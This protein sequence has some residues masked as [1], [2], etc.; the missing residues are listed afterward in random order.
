MFATRRAVTCK[1]IQ[2][3]REAAD[4]LDYPAAVV[5]L[6]PLVHRASVC[7]V[8]AISYADLR[9]RVFRIDSRQMVRRI[10]DSDYSLVLT[11]S[12]RTFGTRRE[13]DAYAI[14]RAFF[15]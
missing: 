14:S 7:V 4:V 15:L 5:A 8:A 2:V 10:R 3:N 13:K 6:E 9:R 12:T 1:P 11:M